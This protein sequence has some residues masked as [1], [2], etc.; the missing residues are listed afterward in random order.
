LAL[1]DLNLSMRGAM[2]E[3]GDSAVRTLPF[4]LPC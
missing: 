4:P 2:L 1:L 3:V